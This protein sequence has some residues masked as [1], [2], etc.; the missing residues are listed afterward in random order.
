MIVIPE[1]KKTEILLIED[2]A[3]DIEIIRQ[4][5][6]GGP[7]P[8]R[9]S[10]VRDGEE[11]LCFLRKKDQFADAKRPDLIL[12]DLNLPKKDGRELLDTI[13]QDPIFKI[14]PVIIIT[15]SQEDRDVIMSYVL[16][17]NAYIVKPVEYEKFVAA[18]TEIQNFWLKT[19]MLP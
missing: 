6:E 1:S 7:V 19:V 12:L 18:L 17:A 3:S 13:K 10:V 2:D 4:S 14:I 8:T 9:V 11:A 16:Q 5:F 15:S